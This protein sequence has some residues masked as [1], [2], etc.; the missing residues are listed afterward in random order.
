MTNSLQLVEPQLLRKQNVS[1]RLPFFVQSE[2]D[3]YGGNSR[4]FESSNRFINGLLHSS[5]TTRTHFGDCVKHA[6]FIDRAQ[7]VVHAATEGNS[8]GIMLSNFLESIEYGLSLMLINGHQQQVG[9]GRNFRGR[10][11]RRRMRQIGQ[12][13]FSFES[14]ENRHEFALK[15]LGPLSVLVRLEHGLNEVPEFADCAALLD[16]LR[17]RVSDCEVRDQFAAELYEFLLVRCAP[18]R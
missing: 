6:R 7:V 4:R 2:S 10:G 1:D 9:A 16:E 11:L 5:G 8:D 12:R 15:E 18:R 3:P 14:I 17:H 13:T